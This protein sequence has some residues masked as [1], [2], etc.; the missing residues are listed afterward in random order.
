MDSRL[1]HLDT[2]RFA[3]GQSPYRY[4]YAP[5]VARP[6]QAHTTLVTRRQ[7]GL[8][9]DPCV[10]LKRRRSRLAGQCRE[11]SRG[12]GDRAADART[13]SPRVDRS[14]ML[15]GESR[16]ATGACSQGER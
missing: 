8:G 4:L 5:N 12:Q 11:F 3:G 15:G 6:S 9:L 14:T 13:R 10:P 2:I 16:R 7:A 1:V